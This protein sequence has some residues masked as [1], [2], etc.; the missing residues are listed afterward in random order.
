MFELPPVLLSVSE[1]TA[2]LFEILFHY[3]SAS[4]RRIPL[5]LTIILR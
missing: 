5:I 1:R 3:E 4:L 2:K